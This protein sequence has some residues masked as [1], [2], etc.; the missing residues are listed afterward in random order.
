MGGRPLELEP[1][2]DLAEEDQVLSQPEGGR[3]E[4]DIPVPEEFLDREMTP[5]LP[6]DAVATPGEERIRMGDERGFDTFAA[7]EDRLGMEPEE[8]IEAPPGVIEVAVGDD[9][10]ID[11]EEVDPHLLG[12][13]DEDARV[14]RIEEKPGSAVL[15]VNGEP[16]FCEEV[17]IGEGG[18]IHE[19]R[20]FHLERLRHVATEVAPPRGR[21]FGRKR[22]H[23]GTG[24]V[25]V[26]KYPAAAGEKKSLPPAKR[27]GG[28]IP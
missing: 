22:V 23:A 15:N 3:C 17:A 20:E 6:P 19:D 18:V 2:L 11:A 9:D 12:V 5:D 26:K 27:Y 4:E 10:V 13:G 24:D 14:A 28:G 16:R 8:G 1:P 21:C 25:A 7:L